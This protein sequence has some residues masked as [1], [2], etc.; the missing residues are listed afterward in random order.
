MRILLHVPTPVRIRDK[1][2]QITLTWCSRLSSTLW[3]ILPMGS[4]YALQRL[5]HPVCS[6][7]KE[8]IPLNEDTI[9]PRSQSDRAEITGNQDGCLKGA[10][11]FRI[12]LEAWWNVACPLIVVKI[13][14]R[15]QTD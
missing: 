11:S 4:A 7:L 14:Q 8:S 12:L 10:Q 2:Y 13:H 15:N 9:S 1:E 3:G 5:V 6:H